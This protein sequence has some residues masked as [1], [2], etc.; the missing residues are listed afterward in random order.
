MKYLV[1]V[2]LIV[3]LS[4]G[5][6]PGQTER[7]FPLDCT[8]PQWTM[9][10]RGDVVRIMCD[11]VWVLSN[12]KYREFVGNAIK[13]DSL[14]RLWAAL[15]EANK[16]IINLKDQIIAHM[17]SITAIQDTAYLALSSRWASTD[18][19]ARESIQNTKAALK[20]ARAIK[21]G[22]YVASGLASGIAAGLAAGTKDHPFQ[23]GYAALGVVAGCG[24]NYLVL[25][26][27]EK[28][29]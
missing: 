16:Q 29:F 7:D 21:F 5:V 26:V 25:E 12:L 8:R 6:C 20:Y 23:P 14:A 15:D 19:V 4:S 13:L 24:I 28:I 3:T 27:V 10:N 22:S 18:S 1:L 17:D 11:S 9:R 2:I